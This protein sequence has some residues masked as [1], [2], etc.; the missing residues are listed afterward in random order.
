[1]TNQVIPDEAVEAAL[2]AWADREAVWPRDVARKIL[3][4][5]APHMLD[6]A[7][8][9]SYEAGVKHALAGIEPILKAEGWDEGY[10]AGAMFTGED[11][12]PRNPYR[13][14]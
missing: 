3:E 8:R 9:Q 5:A 13:T 7:R 6:E 12:G 10:S 2:A 1:M 4:A 14:T 11:D